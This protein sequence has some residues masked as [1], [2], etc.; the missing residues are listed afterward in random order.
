MDHLYVK[1]THRSRLQ[2]YQLLRSD[3]QRKFESQTIKQRMKR[4]IYAVSNPVATLSL[5]A[6]QI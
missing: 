3:D 1:Y 5:C 4:D 6:A 2:F